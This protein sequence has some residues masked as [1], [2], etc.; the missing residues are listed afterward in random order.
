MKT[1]THMWQKTAVMAC[2]LF[3]VLVMVGCRY[4]S[5]PGPFGGGD[6]N[7]GNSTDG[8]G[9]TAVVTAYSGT[10]ALTTGEATAN[11]QT[12][13]P[14]NCLSSRTQFTLAQNA[15]ITDK[16]GGTWTVPSP[17][18]SGS[19]GTDLYND[20]TAS[21]NNDAYASQLQT[22]V[23][24]ED[25]VEITAYIHGDNYFE[26]Y[27]NG[28]LVCEDPIAF[29]PF[30]STACRFKAK[31]PIT[32]A[33][34]AVD[35][36]EHL[37]LGME[38]DSYH[39]GDGGFVASFSDG[40]VTDAT[41]KAEAFYFAPLDDPNCVTEGA[42]G[43]NSATCAKQPTCINDPN[44]CQALHFAE[45][46]DWTAPTFDDAA[47]ETAT[48]YTSDE[49][50]PKEAYTNFAN[51]FGSGQFIWTHNLNIDNL[52]LFRHTVQQAP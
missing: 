33:I 21:G 51:L 14:V 45:P 3:M 50:G 28:Q 42:N 12:V 18:Q 46:T 41:W 11:K 7:G 25:G 43:R 35:W 38:Y 1:S 15:T 27:V 39:V 19:T 34:R 17:V 52:V 48:V 20:C 13:G 31:Y 29:T 10:G 36:E 6:N 47:W 8:S 40:T 22:V 49:F 23:V 44:T 24:D 9:Q 26:L 32:Y 4:G 37:G 16:Q 30:N 5:G 2:S